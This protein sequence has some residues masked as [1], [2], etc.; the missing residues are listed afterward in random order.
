MGSDELVLFWILPGHC[1]R[2][3]KPLVVH[4]WVRSQ[5][6]EEAIVLVNIAEVY[7]SLC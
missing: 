5:S 4:W 1:Q 3:P 6:S 2:L 7:C